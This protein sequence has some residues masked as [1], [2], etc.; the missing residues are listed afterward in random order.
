MAAG[1]DF[2][3]VVL[4]G[5]SGGYA[6]ALRAVELGLRVA[7]VERDRL[8]G[9]CLHKGCIPTKALLQSAE[10]AD[11]VKNAAAFGVAA[12]FGHIDLPAVRAYRDGVV[13][14]LFRGLSGLVANRGI[15][16]VEGV[17]ALTSPTT[18]AVTLN[19]DGSQRVL[20]GTHVLIATGSVPKAVP[21]LDTD[22]AAIITSDDAL[23]LEAVP[24]T[25]L[26]LGGGAIG[27]EFATVWN[28]FG[29]SVTVVEAMRHLVPLEDEACSAALEKAFKR[30]GIGMKLGVKIDAARQVDGGVEA[31]L[32]DGSTLTADVVLIAVGRS[33]VSRGIGLDAVGVELEREFV[34]VDDVCRT[35]VPSIFAVGDVIATPQLA[36]AGFA[37]GILVAETIA[38]LDAQPIDYPGI[39]RVTY[40][41]PEVASVGL[42]T[43]AAVERGYEIDEATYDLAGNGKARIL[44]TSGFVKV[45]AAKN[46]PVLGVHMVGDRVGEL[47][48]EAQLI[49]NWEALPDEV[50]RHIHAHPTVSEAIGEAH[51]ALAGKPLHSHG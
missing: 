24:E 32:S 47:I 31:V 8:G 49:V 1:N 6:A 19:E 27:C 18:V 17:G 28:A 10:V 14:G 46:G 22:G 33:P 25:A 51:L 39:P 23:R 12:S 50:S 41:H 4:G 40:S 36:H 21:G 30:K 16:L 34:K 37:E 48:S 43:R 15:E 38:G 9:T 2:D 44:K 5:G 42:S 11:S 13:Q 29:A 26:I 20:N 7:L 35:S 3:L 45:V